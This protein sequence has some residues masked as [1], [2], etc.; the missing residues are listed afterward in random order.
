MNR[1]VVRVYKGSHLQAASVACNVDPG[2]A[3]VVRLRFCRD[4]MTVDLSPAVA[5]R[6]GEAARRAA[7]VP[8]PRV[9]MR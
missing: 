3:G 9:R 7:L 1:H 4:N 8:T 5:A 2:P 6:V